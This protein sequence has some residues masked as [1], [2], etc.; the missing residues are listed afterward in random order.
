PGLLETANGGTFL[1][2]ELGEAPLSIQAKLLRVIQDGVI[3]RVGSE[4]ADTIID[5][6]F[7]SA[8]NR[9]PEAAVAQGLLRADLFYR[10]RVV[11]IHLP[12]LRERPEDISG[13][14]THF[15]AE[16]WARH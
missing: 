16:Y 14:A 5:V 8:T 12:P 2:D 4:Q 9:D 15:F 11:P 6:R 1:L 7:I 10:L 13:L 3:R